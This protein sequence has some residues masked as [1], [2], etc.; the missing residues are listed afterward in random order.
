V[1]A[2]GD[3]PAVQLAVL[4]ALLVGLVV[5]ATVSRGSSEGAVVPSPTG[6]APSASAD[7]GTVVIR[8]QA[9]GVAELEVKAGMGVRFVNDESV[10]H[11]IAEGKGGQ[12]A[13]DA[14]IPRTRIRGGGTK[15][16]V[17]PE[18][19]VYHLTCIIH[20]RMKMV[21]HVR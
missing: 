2:L 7:G 1:A 20:R 10:T 14:R 13:A 16:I 9:F 11:V 4:L 5:L 21:V 8:N 3:R 15:V 17:F 6:P 19:G 18:P 12:E